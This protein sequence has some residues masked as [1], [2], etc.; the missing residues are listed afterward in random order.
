MSG[1]TPRVNSALLGGYIGR[2]VRLACKVIRVTQTG[3]T[4]VE[5]CDGGQVEIKHSTSNDMTS[6][7]VEV[8]GTVED[9]NHIK[10]LACVNFGSD[11][12]FKLVN[13]CVELMHDPK[14]SEIFF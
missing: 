5:A 2:T 13:D 14:H 3:S 10:Y 1:V 9:E 8:I 7:Y 4:M 6:T 12:D 11:L